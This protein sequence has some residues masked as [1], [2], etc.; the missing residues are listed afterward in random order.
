MYFSFFLFKAKALKFRLYVCSFSEKRR[1]KTSTFSVFLFFCTQVFLFHST[2]SFSL[3]PFQRYHQFPTE[4]K[5][6]F[7]SQRIY[8]Y[9][10]NGSSFSHFFFLLYFTFCFT[11]VSHFLRFHF[12]MPAPQM[13]GS[14]PRSELQ[15]LQVKAQQVTDEVT[16]LQ[17][18][19]FL[20][21][22]CL[23]F[24]IHDSIIII[25]E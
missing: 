11:S 15:E 10:R 16:F 4:P 17:K 5:F 25:I 2:L 13:D 14:G 20:L 23:K 7:C 19:L 12:R 21:F 1:M 22:F 18:I 8:S 3:S 6:V 24:E 9:S